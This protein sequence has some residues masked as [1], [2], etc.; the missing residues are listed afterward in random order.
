MFLAM[1]GTH[2]AQRDVGIKEMLW[3]QGQHGGPE[4]SVQAVDA[5]PLGQCSPFHGAHANRGFA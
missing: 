5:S 3:P 4:N 2:I 1:K